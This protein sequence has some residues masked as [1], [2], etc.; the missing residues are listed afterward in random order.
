MTRVAR[1]RAV[2]A[3]LPAE[4]EAARAHACRLTPDRFLTTVDD[5]R[6]FLRDRGMLTTLPSTSLPSVFGACDPPAP[7]AQGFERWPADKWWWDGALV[8]SEGV[9]T[10]KVAR[11]KRLFVDERLVARFDPLCRA[12]LADADAGSL[13]IEVQQLTGELA[14]SG[15]APIDDVRRSLGLDTAGLRR[16]RAVVEPLGAVVSREVE[17][18]ARNGGH[19]HTSVV[20]RWDQVVPSRAKADRDAMGALLV[21]AV[22]AAV[23]APEAEAE[24]WFSWP[25]APGT[26]DR[27]VDAGRL[28]RPAPGWLGSA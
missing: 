17:I 12:S 10:S 15:P 21:A 22:E 3:A 28:V 5:A 20:S 9:V 14:A 7:G 16:V 4:W 25:V 8:E 24:R 18:A 11:G 19:R 27:L 2:L 6:E 1:A 26:L 13:G 23:A